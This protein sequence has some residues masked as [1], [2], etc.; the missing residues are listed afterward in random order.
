MKTLDARLRT[1]VGAG[2]LIG[3]G[4]LFGLL[5]GGCVTPPPPPD[6]TAFRANRPASIL[7]LPPLNRS[8]DI[9]AGS[10]VLAQTVRPLAEAGYYV[11]PV[12]LMAETFKHNGLTV[13]EDI[14]ATSPERLREIFGADAGLYLTVTRY[15]SQYTIFDS[16]AVVTI[17]GRLIDLRNRQELWHGS[18]TASNQQNNNSQ[19]GLAGLLVSAMLKQ[20]L[21]QALN[22]SHPVAGI[23]AQR[24]LTP[25]AHNG[26]L[27]GPRSP[28]YGKD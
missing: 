9:G 13:P 28:L 2:V 24:L 12:T 25:G 10:S 11:V 27:S 22:T 4:L 8:P 1:T 18:A 14:H 19:G 16:A 15:G 3:L 20:A 26:L 6:T 5:L 23:A 7:V 21:N 17:E